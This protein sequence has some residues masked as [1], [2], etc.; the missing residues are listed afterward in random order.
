MPR[1]GARCLA[2]ASASRSRIRSLIL[3]CTA[4]DTGPYSAVHARYFFA[5]KYA[6]R[7]S[8][9]AERRSAPRG[10]VRS[11]LGLEIITK[12]LF[13]FFSVARPRRVHHCQT[14]PMHFVYI[15]VSVAHPERYYVGLTRNIR[16]R[17]DHHN[18]GFVC[19]TAPFRPWR[20]RS[21]ICFIKRNRASEF[22]HYLK[23]GAGIAFLRKRLL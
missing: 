20:L 8:V 6:L 7:S 21:A 15:I 12:L 5:A 3:A 17:L 9:L 11:N 10:F 22:E 18:K 2:F 1:R 19:S 4:S 13:R 23:T 14:A 16:R